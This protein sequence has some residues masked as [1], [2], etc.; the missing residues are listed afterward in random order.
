VYIKRFKDSKKFRLPEYDYRSDGYYYVTIC[1]K[2]R[3][4]CFGEIRN[5]IMGLNELGCQAAKFWQEIPKNFEN[6]SL[7]EWVI[8]P[9]HIH[10]IV[11]IGCKHHG[12]VGTRHGP[13]GTRHGPVGTRH[14]PVGTRHGVFLR[15]EQFNKFS[16]P[17]SNSL[18]MII[19]HF[20]GSLKRWCNKNGF[21]NFAWQP[22]FYERVLRNE[23]ETNIRRKYI[24]NNPMNW[25][26]DRNNQKSFS[27]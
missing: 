22:R 10:G 17:I 24:Q 27:H 19:N 7:D 18:S 1:T 6:V 2:N 4:E 3:E 13:V 15:D 16:K 20:K 9:N 25:E 8:M 5:G 11:V 12:P 21:Q 14:G 26:W 23:K